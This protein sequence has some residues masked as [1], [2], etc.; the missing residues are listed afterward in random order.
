LP[1][2]DAQVEGPVLTCACPD[3][4]VL[5][6]HMGRALQKEMA[7]GF[8]DATFITVSG[9]ETTPDLIDVKTLTPE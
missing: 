8:L 2:C 9:V 7:H 1:G 4:F 6:A 3:E 5:E